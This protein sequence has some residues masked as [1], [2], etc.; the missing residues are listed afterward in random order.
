MLESRGLEV[1]DTVIDMA[2]NDRDPAALK[3]IMERICPKPKADSVNLGIQ[4]NSLSNRDDIRAM[5][6]EVISGTL[7]GDVPDD[8]G[9]AIASLVKTASD[10]DDKIEMQKRIEVIEERLG[11]NKI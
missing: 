1:I 9:K 5:I 6:S 10:M 3:L 2:L 11:V 7:K 4:V 8:Q